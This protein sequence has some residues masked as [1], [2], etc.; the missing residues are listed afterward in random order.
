M[1]WCGVVVILNEYSLKSS[2]AFKRSCNLP[3]VVGKLGRNIRITNLSCLSF[4]WAQGL[5]V[6]LASQVTNRASAVKQPNALIRLH[7][8]LCSIVP[9]RPMPCSTR[10]KCK[11]KECMAVKVSTE[12]PQFRTIKAEKELYVYVIPEGDPAIFGV[13]NRYPIG[14]AVN[15]TCVF[16]PS[17][18]KRN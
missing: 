17:S 14:S 7:T 9:M 10:V 13:M 12:M 8:K 6:V 4:V 11:P 18:Q 3:I 1:V 16:G 15:V 2:L 5:S